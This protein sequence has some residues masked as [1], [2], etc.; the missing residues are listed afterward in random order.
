MSDKTRQKAT[1]AEP[2]CPRCGAFGPRP[3]EYGYPGDEMLEAG[4]RGEIVL[5]GCVVEDDAPSLACLACG[6]RWGDAPERT[7]GAARIRLGRLD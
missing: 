1:K 2:R 5:G 7:E 3:I 6:H 4:E